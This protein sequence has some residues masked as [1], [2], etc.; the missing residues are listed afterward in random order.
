M[1]NHFAG[2]LKWLQCKM[3][4]ISQLTKDTVE[5]ECIPPKFLPWSPNIQYFKMWPYLD[6]GSADLIS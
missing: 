1:L 4:T 2:H 3:S 5:V 6:I